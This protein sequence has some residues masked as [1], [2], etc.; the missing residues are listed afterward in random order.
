MDI[1]APL[2]DIT[3]TV[4]GKVLGERIQIILCEPEGA[5]MNFRIK[6]TTPFLRLFLKYCETRG[7]DRS[8]VRFLFDGNRVGDFDTPEMLQMQDEDIIDVVMQQIG[9]EQMLVDVNEL[10]PPAALV[11]SPYYPPTRPFPWSSRL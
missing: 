10:Y 11:W 3:N 6:T 2:S 1:P 4:I 9:G 7:V 5:T 8:R